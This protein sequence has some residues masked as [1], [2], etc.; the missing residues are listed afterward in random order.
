[1]DK[2]TEERLE[3]IAE[4]LQRFVEL[5]PDEQKW[6]FPL[7]G[8]AEKRAIAILEEIQGH[9][10][11]YAEIAKLT[12]SHINTVKATLYA[13]EHG[14]VAFRTGSSGKWQTP[15]GGRNRRLKLLE[16]SKK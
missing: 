9:P 4:S 13:L 5:H 3:R 8:R 12:D 15:K 2:N 16:G 7:L 11:S 1:M 10:L 6:L 14:G